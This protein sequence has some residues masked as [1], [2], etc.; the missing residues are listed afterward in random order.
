MRAMLSGEENLQ[1]FIAKQVNSP[2]QANYHLDE[3]C[4]A[5]NQGEMNDAHAPNGAQ[6]LLVE[7]NAI[8]QMVAVNVI[9]SIGLAVT[10][11]S[12]GKEALDVLRKSNEGGWAFTL[13][14]M[15]CQ[16]PEMDGYE[17]TKQ[18]RQGKAGN[19]NINIPIIAMTA[20]AMQGD[21]EKCLQAGMSDFLTK[22]VDRE[23]LVDKLA[24]W[25][26]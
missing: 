25:V 18:I 11:A 2:R 6:V 23:K 13:V 9:E 21:K 3:K 10:V 4:G 12:N 16:M 17:A 5:T 7:D 8:N 15:D 14:I 26:K 24:H 20:N 19:E 1:P 22:P